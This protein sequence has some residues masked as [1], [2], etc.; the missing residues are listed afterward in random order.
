MIR[1][2]LQSLSPA[3][4]EVLYATYFARR[5]T[6]EAAAVLGIPP[7]A[8]ASRLYYA[9]RQLKLALGER[10]IAVPERGAVP[11]QL[12]GL[13]PQ[14]R[15]PEQQVPQQHPGVNFRP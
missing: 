3:H 5:T 1:D 6:R 13:V 12:G 11:P 7:S 2:A 10:G 9:L 8:V 14:Q 15:M 4:Q